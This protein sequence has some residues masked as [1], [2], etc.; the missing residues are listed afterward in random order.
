M[1]KDKRKNDE[2]RKLKIRKNYLK[3]ADG[4]C[5]IEIGAT[6]VVCSFDSSQNT[7][8]MTGRNSSLP[9]ANK[10]LFIAL[11][12]TLPLIIVDV[13]ECKV[14]ILGNSSAF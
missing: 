8:D 7:P 5:S 14:G 1:R 11:V 3:F 4:S 10:V 12:S 2:P 13:E 9:L 6:K